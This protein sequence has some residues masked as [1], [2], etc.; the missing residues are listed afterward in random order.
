[1]AGTLS[2]AE[3]EAAYEGVF[4]E[5]RAAQRK[6]QKRDF[7]L[8]IS[9]GLGGIVL[10]NLS[11]LLGE[12]VAR[13]LTILILVSTVGAVM[14]MT[15]IRMNLPSSIADSAEALDELRNAQRAWVESHGLQL[16]GGAFYQLTFPMSPDKT[17]VRTYGVTQLIDS[18][19]AKLVSVVLRSTP[20]AGY[21]LFGTEG[22]ILKPVLTAV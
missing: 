22:E 3:A 12:P 17:A 18:T 4:D 20:E 7:L 1:M 11:L 15:I 14:V 21:Q 10:A 6:K 9:V 19:T 8:P 5:I 2:I 13:Y 16:S